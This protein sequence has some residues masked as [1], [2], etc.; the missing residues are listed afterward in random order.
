MGWQLTGF[1]FREYL[2]VSPESRG[3]CF[4]CIDF[5]AVIG[6]F[7]HLLRYGCF[8]DF[9]WFRF[10]DLYGHDKFIAFFQLSDGNRL[11]V[12]QE[13][14]LGQFP[15]YQCFSSETRPL[16]PSFWPVDVG[17]KG[18][19]PWVSEDKS[20]PSEVRDEEPGPFLFPVS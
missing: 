11:Y 9:H 6:F 12:L 16:D 14:L 18:G 5:S 19:Q 4:F 17:V 2:P 15:F 10:Q 13:F 1:L 7:G 8:P 3:D 20:V